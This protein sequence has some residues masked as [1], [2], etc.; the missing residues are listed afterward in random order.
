[1]IYYLNEFK[2]LSDILLIILNLVRLLGKKRTL[3]LACDSFSL[4]HTGHT[5]SATKH[6][7][8]AI[9]LRMK[10]HIHRCRRTENVIRQIEK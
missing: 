7:L 4:I 5:N 6:N 2:R 1:M 9:V 10:E 8:D 3:L